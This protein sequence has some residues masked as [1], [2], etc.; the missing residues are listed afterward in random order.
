MSTGYVYHP[1]YLKHN[2]GAHPERSERLIAILDL[3]K[4]RN[5]LDQLVKIN[6]ER[7]S[8]KEIEYN[9]DPAYIRHVQAVSEREGALDLD[10]PVSKDSFDAAL[11]AAG[12]L[13][14][15][16]DQVMSKK[17]TNAFALVRPPGHHAEYAKGMGFCLF[18]NVAIAARH[19]KLHHGLQR[20]LIIDWD[21]HH[22]NGTEHSFYDDPSVLYFSIHQFPHYPGTGRVDDIGTGEGEGFTV[23][24]PLPPGVGDKG[25]LEV[26]NEVL[27][28]IATEFNPEFILISSGSDL[29]K[30]DPLGGMNV[31]SPA[32][33]KFT[34][35]VM[36]IGDRVVVTLEGGYDL[37]GLSESVLA[38]FGSLAGI[39][40]D[41]GEMTLDR[42][43][44]DVAD[45]I[46]NVK[47]VQ[48]SY[49]N[50]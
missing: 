1:I 44:R 33:G 13:I 36:E 21:V 50:I 14:G 48:R 43:E 6:A 10:T 42:S 41:T 32:F 34:D 35:I 28:P 29:H 23:N 49:W 40:V 18:N 46:S 24:V 5:M 7:A 27:L 20:I 31:T 26:M 25:Y 3:L 17:V 45:V 9:H 16:V 19:L 2:T 39:E 8:I 12:G 38:I 47:K 22:G 30:L 15:A 11:Y 37:T 4:K